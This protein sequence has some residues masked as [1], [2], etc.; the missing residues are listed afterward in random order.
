MSAC[1]AKYQAWWDD[2]SP[3]ERALARELYRNHLLPGPFVTSLARAG[4]LQLD[5]PHELGCEDGA[6]GISVRDDLAEF[7]DRKRESA[8]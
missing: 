7:L 5:D 4:L 8:V 3:V 6:L 1:E 2:L